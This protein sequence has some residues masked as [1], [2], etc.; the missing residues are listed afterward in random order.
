MESRTLVNARAGLEA[1]DGKW[2]VAVWGKNLTDEEWSGY[3]YQIV[4]TL[5][6][7]QSPVTYGVSLSYN[8]F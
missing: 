3:S 5:H 7:D 1:A 6:M 4:D 8:F 2:E